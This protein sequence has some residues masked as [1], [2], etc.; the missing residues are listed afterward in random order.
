M[1]RSIAGIFS[2]AILVVQLNPGLG[3]AGDRRWTS[4]GPQGGYIEA[5]AI[6]PTA[7]QTLYAGAEGTGMFKS[8][9]GGTLW[10]PINR[11]LISDTFPYATVRGVVI[12]PS[13]PQTI[14]AVTGSASI[15]KSVDGGV[16]WSPA[17]TGLPVDSVLVLAMDPTEPQTLYAST[18]FFGVFKSVNGGGGWSPTGLTSAYVRSFAIDPTATQVLYAGANTGAF[19]STDGGDNWTPINTGLTSIDVNALAID[20]TAPQ[21]LYAGSID[22]G[23]VWGYSMPPV[24]RPVS[25]SRRAAP[26][27]P[28]PW[29]AMK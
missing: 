1:S 25:I 11:G 9:D 24:S 3:R 15:S 17:N 20:P 12:D 4:L 28:I 16:S 5:L 8:T 26:R 14:Y 19:K 27:R 21:T 6:D 13:V 22:N 18:A 10:S 23:G 29:A 7:P 2:A